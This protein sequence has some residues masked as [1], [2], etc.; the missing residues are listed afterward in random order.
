M[1]EIY[2]LVSIVLINLVWVISPGPWFL[3]VVK[4]ALKDWKS[5]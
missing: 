4:N 3:I 2:F 1:T 5:W